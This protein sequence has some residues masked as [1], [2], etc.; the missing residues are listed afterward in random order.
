MDLIKNIIIVL[1]TFLLCIA[2]MIFVMKTQKIKEKRKAVVLLIGLL[3]EISLGICVGYFINIEDPP[4]PQKESITDVSIESNNGIN[5]EII[6]NNNNYNN[7]E[8]YPEQTSSSISLYESKSYESTL[9]QT[10]VEQTTKKPTI[11]LSFEAFPYS[12]TDNNGDFRA[13][14]SFEAKKVTLCC[15]VDGVPYGEF[16]MKTDDLHNWTYDACFFEP[17]TYVLTAVAEEAS[18]NVYSNSV[19]VNYPFV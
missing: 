9:V 17:N 18:G 6:N 19:T 2:Y 11:F 15:E 4:Q 13:Y 8:N 12:L 1:I 5:I 14:T 3:I 10:T 7:N 16:D